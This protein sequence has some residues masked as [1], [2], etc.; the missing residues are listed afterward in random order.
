M[1]DFTAI[2]KGFNERQ[3]YN[4]NK[5][6]EVMELFEEFKRNNPEATMADFQ[7]FRD[8]VSGGRNYLRGGVGNDA[9]LKRIVDTNERK[10]Q[11]AAAARSQ[12]EAMQKLQFMRELQ[13]FIDNELVNMQEIK[14][15]PA[16]QY[17]GYDTAGAI[18]NVKD[19]FGG[20]LPFDMDIT[21]MMS[22]GNR[23]RAVQSMVLNKLPQAR[24]YIG[25]LT[26]PSQ[27]N[28]GELATLLQV[29][30]TVAQQLLDSATKE[31]EATQGEKLRNLGRTITGDIEKLALK[32]D[33]TWD[34]VT[35]VLDKQYSDDPLYKKWKDTSLDGS[36][37][38][39]ENTNEEINNTRDQENIVTLNAAVDKLK[40]AL[41][42]GI[43]S[44]G[45]AEATKKFK[46]DLKRNV[47]EALHGLITDDYVANEVEGLRNQAAQVQ[48]DKFAT[49][50]SLQKVENRKI[51]ATLLKQQE[52]FVTGALGTKDGRFNNDNE[53]L[54]AA[55][56]MAQLFQ[57]DNNAITIMGSLAENIPSDATFED[58]VA[59]FR[60]GLEDKGQIKFGEILERQQELSSAKSGILEPQ[61][62]TQYIGKR[63][64]D[65]VEIV[66]AINNFVERNRQ[67]G[68]TPEKKIAKLRGYL[69]RV[70][71]EFKH[72]TD[73][74]EADRIASIGTI[75]DQSN[76]YI[77]LDPETPW[78][79]SEIDKFMKGASLE[80]DWIN[81]QISAQ[82]KAIKERDANR[83]E[84]GNTVID[85]ES[86]GDP[87]SV[88]NDSKINS[89]VTQT[90]AG[91]SQGNVPTTQEFVRIMIDDLNIKRP[92]S[93]NEY[94]T[95]FAQDFTE[96]VKL[97][98]QK[99][100]P[101]SQDMINQIAN[102]MLPKGLG[103]QPLRL[104]VTQ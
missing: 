89:V 16:N 39:F 53:L 82:Q 31:Y 73:V 74:I 51:G 25:D 29:P 44:D 54:V 71:D 90:A 33:M 55:K 41:L 1:I 11:Q 18:K 32:P 75:S 77:W 9:A 103:A 47:V 78:D 17:S 98:A 22:E 83:V 26:D 72:F 65:Y 69:V 86:F 40:P 60:K 27:A 20:S 63:T 6:L 96:F 95:S 45:V 30:Q 12:S 57:M 8:Q 19:M 7:S 21:N 49:A 58:K 68:E 35:S 13:P 100:T 38:V 2:S 97:M 92:M 4:R 15:G 34:E 101:L 59:I 52:D 94:E 56:Q 62:F 85:Q 14:G 46:E 67:N 42:A 10:R 66:N 91:M 3:D 36:K 76:N 64:D 99:G 23:S 28:A 5:R 93:K 24:E 102:E 48:Q 87:E 88:T 61:T 43:Q 50:N 70:K 104:T 79:Q 84:F 80:I 37:G 81:K